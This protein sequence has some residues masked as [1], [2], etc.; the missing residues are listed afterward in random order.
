MIYQTIKKE[1]ILM[2]FQII[3]QIRDNLILIIYETYK[4]KCKVSYNSFGGY[5]IKSKNCTKQMIIYR[6]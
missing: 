1:I 5:Q 4:I 6:V 3:T 2:N